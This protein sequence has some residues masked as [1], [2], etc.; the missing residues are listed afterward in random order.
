V[1]L[2]GWLRAR[3]LNNGEM[4]SGIFDG[5]TKE[6]RAELRELRYYFG[7]SNNVS[8]SEIS[9]LYRSKV[10]EVHPDSGGNE[11]EVF[12]NLQLKYNRIKTLQEKFLKAKNFS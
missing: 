4:S 11:V 5:M 9:K 10:R 1:G 7:V 2:V 8:L 12:L 3:N 6:E